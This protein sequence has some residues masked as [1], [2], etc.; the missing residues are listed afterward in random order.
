MLSTKRQAARSEEK[1]S[2]A[3]EGSKQVYLAVV[4]LSP[5]ARNQAF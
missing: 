4:A 1:P 3:L 2:P 5:K